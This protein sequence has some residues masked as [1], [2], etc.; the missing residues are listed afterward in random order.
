MWLSPRCFA[1]YR[2]GAP[3]MH[4]LSRRLVVVTEDASVVDTE[5][6]VV[7][8]AVWGPCAL[9]TGRVWRELLCRHAGE[10]GPGGIRGGGTASS[11][12]WPACVLRVGC[13][14]CR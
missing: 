14:P 8:A 3:T 13:R 12:R 2:S 5:P 11:T 9:C 1:R 4:M 10:R 7:A 6:D